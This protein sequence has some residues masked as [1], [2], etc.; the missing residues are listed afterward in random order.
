MENSMTLADFF[1]LWPLFGDATLTGTFAGMTLGVLGVHVVLRRMVFLTAAIAQTASLGVM[2]AVALMPIAALAWLAKPTLV[3]LLMTLITLYVVHRARQS[4]RD[5]SDTMLGF[6]YLVGAAGTLVLGAR[7]HLELHDL[8]AMLFGTAVAVMRHDFLTVVGVS[9]AI[10]LVQGLAWRGFA[11]VTVDPQDAQ[12]RELPVRLLDLTLMFSLATMISISTRVLGPLPT[13]AFSILP[14]LAAVRLATNVQRALLIA[15]LL[16][17]AMG[18][19]G[20]VVATLHDLP[21]GPAQACVG[22]AFVVLSDLIARV[23]EPLRAKRTKPVE[24][25]ALRD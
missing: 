1:S 24:T 3:A 2:V 16:G 7:V 5:F 9:T 19:I 4:R 18:F 21:V 23:R 11:A 25:A 6:M 15:A 10:I 17:A 8:S 12:I 13:F 14:A 22:I 20:Y